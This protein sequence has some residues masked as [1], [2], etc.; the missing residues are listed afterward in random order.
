MLPS[1]PCQRPFPAVATHCRY[2]DRQQPLRSSVNEVPRAAAAICSSIPQSVVIGPI[3]TV[4]DYGPSFVVFALGVGDE[5]VFAL[6]PFRT[7]DTI[8]LS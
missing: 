7:F 3:R 8:M 1:P 4:Y 2:L 5:V 6:K